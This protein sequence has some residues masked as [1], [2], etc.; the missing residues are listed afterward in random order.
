M[1]AKKYFVVI[2]DIGQ[3]GIEPTFA[4]VCRVYDVEL[5]PNDRKEFP[6]THGNF[7]VHRV[8][9]CIKIKKR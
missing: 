5:K 7:K 3:I 6:Q 2:N 8:E 4:A 9:P 1:L